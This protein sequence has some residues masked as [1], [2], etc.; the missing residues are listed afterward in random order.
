M[1]KL[2]LLKSMLRKHY[3]L[4]HNFLSQGKFSMKYY[5]KLNY[6]LKFTQIFKKNYN[7]TVNLT[8]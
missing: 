7:A 5:Q 4:Y 3:I 6:Y 2:F 8:T 1:L